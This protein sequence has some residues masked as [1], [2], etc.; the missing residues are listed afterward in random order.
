MKTIDNH[1]SML[2]MFCILFSLAV[3]FGN[4]KTSFAAQAPASL[5]EHKTGDSIQIFVHPGET[6]VLRLPE[7]RTTGY[8]WQ[9]EPLAADAPIEPAGE[10]TMVNESPG[11]MVGA[12]GTR[13]WR[14]KA[15]KPGLTVIHAVYVRPWEKPLKPVKTA[16]VEIIVEAP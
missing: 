6:A 2:R 8:M 9:L 4:E 13:E 3:F 5:Q 15:L 16:T 1:Q 14:Y 12:G 11:K 10:E 7:N